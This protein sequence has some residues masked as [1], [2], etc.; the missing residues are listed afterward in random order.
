M[1]GVTC[2][3]LPAHWTNGWDG[4]S[5]SDGAGFADPAPLDVG[6]H[7]LGRALGR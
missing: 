1:T 3:G 7:S 6:H 4:S 2:P 5:R